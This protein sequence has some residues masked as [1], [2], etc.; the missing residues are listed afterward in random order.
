M[1]V[2]VPESDG[3]WRDAHD[4]DD[5]DDLSATPAPAV[6][7][8]KRDTAIAGVQAAVAVLAQRSVE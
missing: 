4:D 3:E 8:P 1:R 2:A 7:R 5:D 6:S